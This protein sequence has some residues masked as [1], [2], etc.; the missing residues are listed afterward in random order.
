MLRNKVSKQVIVEVTKFIESYQISIMGSRNDII[1]K[2]KLE[3]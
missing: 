3:G 2:H 1:N